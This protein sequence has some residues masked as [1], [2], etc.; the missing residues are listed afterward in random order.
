[1]KSGKEPEEYIIDKAQKF[2]NKGRDKVKKACDD[3]K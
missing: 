1:M 3:A 2:F